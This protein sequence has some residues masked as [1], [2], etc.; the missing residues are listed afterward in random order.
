MNKYVTPELDIWDVVVEV[1]FN[2]SGAVA[3][4]FDNENEL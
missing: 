4:D 3:P 1:G 2:V